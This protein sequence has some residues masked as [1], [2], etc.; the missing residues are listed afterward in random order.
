M[1]RMFDA[2]NPANIPSSLDGTMALNI[3]V[4]A[5]PL[6]QA[7]D[8]EP[9]NVAAGPVAAAM[10]TRLRAGKWSVGYVNQDTIGPL[11]AAMSAVGIEWAQA[12]SWPKPGVYL[13]AADPSGNIMAGRWKLPVAALAIQDT[14]QGGYD[15]STTAPNF[16][17]QV[18]G[19]L[20]GPVSAWPPNIWARYTA[21]VEP[22]PPPAPVPIPR[23]DR[24]MFL[25][26]DGSTQYV[27]TTTATGG[28]TKC[29]IGGINDPA[30]PE[31]EQ[32]AAAIGNAGTIPSL[33]A[34][35]P[36]GPHI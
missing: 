17:A 30:H 5:N 23:R 22:P 25:A 34:G 6:G 1:G 35:I 24:E 21:I 19:Y 26:N 32:L 20:D 28:L 16:P 11:T 36:E 7:F 12:W 15:V 8:V 13:W 3:T 29:G 27:V 4:L 14:Y 9:G 33:L 10:L 2:V 18:A 31:L